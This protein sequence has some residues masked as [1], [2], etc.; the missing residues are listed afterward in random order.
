MSEDRREWTPDKVR[1]FN[2]QPEPKRAPIRYYEDSGT[3]VAEDDDMPRW[4]AVAATLTEVMQM[5]HDAKLVF[6]L[7]EKVSALEAELAAARAELAE[8]EALRNRMSDLLTR[9]ANALKGEP[10]PLT[11]H[12]WSDLPERAGLIVV[13]EARLIAEVEAM[14]PV[15]EAA[16]AEHKATVQYYRGDSASDPPDVMQRYIEEGWTRFDA[17]VEVRRIALR[18]ELDRY[19]AATEDRRTAEGGPQ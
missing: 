10:G 9:T 7:M 11:L 12:D 3:W 16:V 18:A 15:V 4:T 6:P 14:R 8:D 2:E 1:A 13:N 5:H 17:L 19:L